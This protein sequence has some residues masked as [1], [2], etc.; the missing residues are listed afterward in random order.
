MSKMLRVKVR[1]VCISTFVALSVSACAMMPFDKYED[2]K[3]RGAK[4]GGYS[5]FPPEYEDKYMMRFAELQQEI[6]RL[7]GELEAS[8]SIDRSQDQAAAQ[9]EQQNRIKTIKQQ[10]EAKVAEVKLEIDSLVASLSEQIESVAL[11][12]AELTAEPATYNG[13]KGVVIR[14]ENANEEIIT[15]AVKEA[16][17]DN[18][19]LSET[20]SYNVV[21]VYDHEPPQD[22]MWTALEQGAVADKWRGINRKKA[23][24]FIYVGVYNGKDSA[25]QRQRT[26]EGITGER[27]AIQ[28]QLRAPQLS[29]N[30]L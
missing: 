19:Q 4:L 11:P 27:P 14:T 23:S 20:Y 9:L 21:Y 3:Y 10:A 12:I 18:P 13:Q 30:D 8:K 15:A 2:S 25:E 24:Y 1:S 22:T 6:D 5:A 28:A 7:S 26:L 16:V 29:L 17:E